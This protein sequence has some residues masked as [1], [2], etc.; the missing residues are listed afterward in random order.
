MRE[1]KDEGDVQGGETAPYGAV[2]TDTWHCV[3]VKISKAIRAKSE[4]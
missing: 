4:P 3:F 1:G 2:M